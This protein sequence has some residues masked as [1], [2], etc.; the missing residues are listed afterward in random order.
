VSSVTK[1]SGFFHNADIDGFFGISKTNEEKE[2]D[3]D[4]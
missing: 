2:P 3:F 4:Q 1:V